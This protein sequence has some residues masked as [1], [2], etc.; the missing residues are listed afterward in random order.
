MKYLIFRLKN[1]CVVCGDGH[2]ILH[3]FYLHVTGLHNNGI[4]GPGRSTWAD[5]EIL[6]SFFCE[7]CGIVYQTTEAN[8]LE[9]DINKK[10]ALAQEKFHPVKYMSIAPKEILIIDENQTKDA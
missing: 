6:Q 4:I 9:G 10:M 5:T 7:K 3:K 2:H 8:N 1:T